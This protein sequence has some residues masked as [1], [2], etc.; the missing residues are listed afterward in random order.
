M[1]ATGG[2]DQT[3]KLW[4]TIQSSDGSE[5]FDEKADWTRP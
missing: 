4:P 1:L 3:V 5:L 2:T